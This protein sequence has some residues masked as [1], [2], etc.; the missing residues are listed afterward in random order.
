LQLYTAGLKKNIEQNKTNATLDKR[1]PSACEHLRP[2]ACCSTHTAI[3]I[4]YH[5]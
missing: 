1:F 5:S 4:L 3:P 2:K